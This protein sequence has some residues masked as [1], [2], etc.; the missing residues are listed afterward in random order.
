MN[1]T[2]IFNATSAANATSSSLLDGRPDKYTAGPILVQTFL[3]Y[4][5]QGEWSSYIAKF[6]HRWEDDPVALRAYV[7][8]L[9][10]FSLLQTVLESYKV[11]VETIDGKHWWTSPLHSTEF[12]F[13]AL[14]CSLC[15]VF[16]I[17]RCFRISQRNIYVLVYLCAL[18]VTS[19]V[20]SIYLTFRIAKF[21]GPSSQHG[22]ADPLH[23]S[24]FAYPLWVYVTLVMALS[25]TV[26]LS[27]ALW[28]TRTGL[29]HLDHTL[30][31][32]IYITFESA[33]LPTAC[34]LA[35]AIV[36][37]VRD[38]QAAAA[39]SSSPPPPS[40]SSS[41]PSP[42]PAYLTGHAAAM[43]HLDLFFAILTGKVYTLGLLRTLNSRTQFRAGLHTS[44]LG[45]RSLSAWDWAG[46][47]EGGG[48]RPSW[49]GSV[50]A[51][52]AQRGASAV[53]GDG[54]EAGGGG[55]SQMGKGRDGVPA[56]DGEGK[57][58]DGRKGGDG[59]REE[60]RESEETMRDSMHDPGR[61]S[62]QVRLLHARVML[63]GSFQVLMLLACS[64]IPRCTSPCPRCARIV[65]ETRA[66]P[67]ITARIF[68][69]VYCLAFDVFF[70]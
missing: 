44:H 25:L 53:V 66:V 31:H 36:Y 1:T 3:Q 40:S 11:W 54:G 17:R 6:Y 68:N 34:M 18:L 41:S 28:R 63:A 65:R 20:G 13:N 14:I 8:V 10:L 57:G 51:P 4:L 67:R 30:N 2:S 62:V 46:N 50:L 45:R 69:I 59:A 70:P 47:A 26:I 43:G 23:A 15:E 22:Y 64:R 19:F 38:A 61:L 56:G 32:I 48:A 5:C 52:R 24:M 33:A 58:G 49:A 29:H 35:S 9:L 55:N 16:L 27:V 39:S 60:F 37:S 7:L 21:I 12:I 42:L